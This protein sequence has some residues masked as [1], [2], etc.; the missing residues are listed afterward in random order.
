M[1]LKPLRRC[2][3]LWGWYLM[4]KPSDRKIKLNAMGYCAVMQLH[5][6]VKHIIKR[7]GPDFD[8]GVELLEVLTIQKEI[9][10][11]LKS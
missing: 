10:L 8:A 3:S 4:S 1:E 5:E 7:D 2:W 9:T 11:K 6:I